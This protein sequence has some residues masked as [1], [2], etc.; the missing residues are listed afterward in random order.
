MV[1]Y[2]DF[3]PPEADPP[4]ADIF[5][6]YLRLLSDFIFIFIVL[7]R[8]YGLNSDLLMST[9]KLRSAASVGIR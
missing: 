6:L 9:D 5:I 3:F 2:F 8:I 7:T 4:L 1:I